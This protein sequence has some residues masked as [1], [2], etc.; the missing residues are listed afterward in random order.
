MEPLLYLVHRIP[1]P[2]N[3]GDK[4]RSYHLLRHLAERHA[5]H[6]GTFVDLRSDLAH[7]AQVD[8]LCASHHIAMLEPRWA[9]LRSASGFV[10]SE[11]LTLPYYRD[12][13]LRR[14]VRRV[15]TQHR[16]RKA[17][18]FSAA[19]AQY[20]ADIDGLHV[21]LDFVDVDSA[22][23]SQ[24]A[25]QRSWPLSA[26][27]RR[28]GEK[29]FAFE[30]RAAQRSAASVFVTRGEAE[31]F[32]AAAPDL[33]AGVHVVENGVNTDY[34]APRVERPSPYAADQ[35]P[36]VFTGA[37]DYWPNVDAVVWFAHE[38][39]PRVRQMRP[40]AS[41][42]IVG[43]NPAPAVRALASRP[44]IVV[45]GTVAD[46]RPYVQ[47]AAA[48]VAPL[49]V[50]RGIQNKILEAM[51]LARPVVVSAA[52]SAGVSGLAGQ[53]FEVADGPETFAMKTV[54]LL[55][56]TIGA[57]IGSAARARILAAYSWDRNLAAFDRLLG[58]EAAR[59][60]LPLGEL[61]HAR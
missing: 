53:E 1:F 2:P 41:F 9:R 7:V 51:A 49:R 57:R 33:R 3:K 29:L 56:P 15:V 16:I 48:V 40:D 14:W 44:G 46:V 22:K 10:T 11:A 27:Y 38:V 23:W 18:V 19:M 28:E 43:M 55:D 32:L 6:L 45:T 5:V 25:Q 13:T 39:L 47:H 12:A 34:F 31:L 59:D 54:A 36:V 42:Y 50:A 26:V 60:A 35:V 17:V 30:R 4:I 24:Y 8:D 20:V 37:M 61:A 52:A 21:V 58:T